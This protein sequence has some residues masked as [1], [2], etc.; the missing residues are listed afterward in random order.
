MCN[1]DWQ[2]DLWLLP[3]FQNSS[4]HVSD[5]SSAPM[6][7]CFQ[8]WYQFLELVKSVMM[9]SQIFQHNHLHMNPLYIKLRF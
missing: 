3:K 5:E 9:E 4:V 2:H 8:I 7:D 6:K 1:S